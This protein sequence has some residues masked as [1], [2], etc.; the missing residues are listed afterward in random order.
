MEKKI[1][2]YNLESIKEL[3][4]QNKYYITASARSYYV[5]LGIDDDEV[6]DVIFNLLPADLYKS[7]TSYNNSA[8]WQDVYHSKLREIKLYIK[9]QIRQEAIVISFKER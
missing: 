8:I 5:G 1:A 6:L 9:L 7:M 4:H 3:M 2:H